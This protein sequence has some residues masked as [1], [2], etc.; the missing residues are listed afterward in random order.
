MKAKVLIAPDKFKGSLTS[1]EVARALAEGLTKFD[2]TIKPIAD[3]GDGTSEIFIS[4]GF[5][6]K[7]V[8]VL[9]PLA[10]PITA[11]YLLKGATAVIE[12]AKASGIALL[13][14]DER[15]AV[16]STSYGTGQLIKDA[17]ENGAREIILAIGGSASTDGG[18]GMLQALG[19]Q[20]LD[21]RGEDIARGGGALIDIATVDLTPLKPL[22]NGVSFILLTDVDNPLLGPQGAAEIYGPQ[23]GASPSDVAKLDRALARFAYLLDPSKT[24]MKGAG[25][26]G[27]VG[28]GAMSA[29]GAVRRSGIE[30]I[31]EYLGLLDAINRCDIFI[32]GEGRFDEQSAMGKG[33]FWLAQVAQQAGKKVIIV[34]GSATITSFDQTYQLA[35][36]EPDLS[37]SMTGARELLIE[38]GKKINEAN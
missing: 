7:S 13:T 2:I 35:D 22:I 6:E 26:A 5:K 30:Y 33:P 36:L 10:R 15:D 34:C 29:L 28:Y 12:M 18:A 14:P 19:A 21:S 32:T 37:K 11:T 20:L 1:L 38:I 24:S 31:A 16:K 17:I 9:D 8:E 4:E 27:G 25:A 3:G 23:K